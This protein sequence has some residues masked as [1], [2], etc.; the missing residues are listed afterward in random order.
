MEQS[1]CWEANRSQLVKK[2]PQF[3][4]TRKF[5]NAFTEALHLS[6]S[7]ARSIQPMLPSRTL[8]LNLI[9]ILPSTPGSSKWSLSLR[10]PHQDPAYTSPLPVHATCPA[11][12]ILLDLINRIIFGE[13]YRSL[14]SSCFLYSLVISY[15]L[16]PNT[17]P[18]TLFPNILNL[19]S[20]LNVS[21]QV[22]ETMDTIKQTAN[23]SNHPYLL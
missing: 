7:W 22:M 8:K 1:A 13:G 9:V 15:I 5:I 19:R 18:S 17:L 23:I 14:S 3:Y 4:G 20:S 6:L 10:F 16:E 2:F 11:H 21:D 12:L